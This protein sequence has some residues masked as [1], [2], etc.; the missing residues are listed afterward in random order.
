MGLHELD[1]LP[2]QL[3][4]MLYIQLHKGLITQCPIFQPLPEQVRC[5]WRRTCACARAL[6]RAVAKR[7]RGHLQPDVFGMHSHLTARLFLNGA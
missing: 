5:P 6:M 3:Q 2:Y 1:E 7:C 4:M